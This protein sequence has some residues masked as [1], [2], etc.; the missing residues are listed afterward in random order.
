MHALY[1]DEAQVPQVER[2]LMK[3]ETASRPDATQRRTCRPSMRRLV[4]PAPDVLP[5]VS[6]LVHAQRL[7]QVGVRPRED[8]PII[9]I[10]IIIT[11]TSSSGRRP[12]PRGCT[13][14]RG[15][16]CGADSDP[17]GGAGPALFTPLDEVDGLVGGDEDDSERLPDLA[18]LEEQVVAGHALHHHLFTARGVKRPCPQQPSDMLSIDTSLRTRLMLLSLGEVR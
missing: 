7:H 1:G 3:R 2:R 8:A 17:V 15:D 12:P 9:V 13:W 4:P 16:T 14:R 5:D 18:D 11:T 10:I 6:Q